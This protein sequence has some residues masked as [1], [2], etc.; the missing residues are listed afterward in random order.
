MKLPIEAIEGAEEQTELDQA[1]HPV[2]NVKENEKFE[3]YGA[4]ATL[5]YL[6]EDFK[7]K[8][9]YVKYLERQIRGSLELKAY[10]S[11]I[12]EHAEMNDCAIFAG[13]S[14]EDCRIE[15]HHFP[16]SL[17]DITRIVLDDALANNEDVSSFTIV[18]RVVLEH[19]LGNV[20]LIPLS[21]TAHE[22]AHAGQITLSLKS[23][24]GNW[25]NFVRKF[26]Y[27]M[28]QEDLDKLQFLIRASASPSLQDANVRKLRIMPRTIAITAKLDDESN[29][30][31]SNVQKDQGVLPET[32]GTENKEETGE[33]QSDVQ[34]ELPP[35]I[36]SEQGS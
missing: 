9:K 2:L 11:F 7:E 10:L 14:R 1:L 13:V 24:T 36:W 32:E 22:L 3:G 29:Q 16:F 15:I 31:E 19:F 35:E 30:G 27:V 17:F 6:K 23:V 4:F 21:L 28:T 34:S 8:A 33:S 20:G 26:S 5:A 12:K 18:S 25:Q